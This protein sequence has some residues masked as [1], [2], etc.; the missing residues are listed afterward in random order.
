[1][2]YIESNRRKAMDVIVE[3]MGELDILGDKITDKSKCNKIVQLMLNLDVKV[4][5]DLNYILFALCKRH[6][7]PSYNNYKKYITKL[8]CHN[9]NLHILGDLPEILHNFDNFSIMLI[10]KQYTEY[11]SNNIVGEL[12]CC[13]LEIYRKLVAP[14]EELKEK[15]NGTV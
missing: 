4:D 13:V 1:M 9:S 3:K 6:V 5:G 11:K 12:E 10:K 2:P 14:Y 15:K 7:K 8:F